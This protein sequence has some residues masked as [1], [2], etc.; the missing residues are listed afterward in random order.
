MTVID[1]PCGQA[2]EARWEPFPRAPSS[3]SQGLSQSSPAVPVGV[4]V[5]SPEAKTP[6]FSVSQSVIQLQL[7]HQPRFRHPFFREPH[8]S[9]VFSFFRKLEGEGREGTES[10]GCLFP[11]QDDSSWRLRVQA[12]ILSRGAQSPSWVGPQCR[13]LAPPGLKAPPGCCEHGRGSC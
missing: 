4:E 7:A 10:D 12:T 11:G 5:G 2:G 9:F 8:Q 6:L 1:L 13:N 3:S